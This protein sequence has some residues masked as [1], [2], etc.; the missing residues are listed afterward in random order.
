MSEYSVSSVTSAPAKR[1]VRAAVL[2]A[3]GAMT[4]A[5]VAEADAALAGRLAELVAPDAA[6]TVCATLRPTHS[7]DGSAALHL[8]GRP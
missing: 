6:L 2:A 4:P 5:A 7:S 8:N 1:E 3:R